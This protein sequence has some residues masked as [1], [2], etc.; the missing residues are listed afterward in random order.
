MAYPFAPMVTLGEFIARAMNDYK[1]K[2]KRIKADLN[3]PRGKATV[4]FLSRIGK[5]GE[6]KIAV[7]PDTRKDEHLTPTILRS[8]C[9]QLDIPPIDFGLSLN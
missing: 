3:G 4:E 2:K 8:L 7:I 1:A 9:N 5:D 6:T